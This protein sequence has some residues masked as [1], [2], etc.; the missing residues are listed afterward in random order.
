MQIHQAS[1]GYHRGH[2]L[3]AS[4]SPA[5]LDLFRDAAWL[6]DLPQT[7]PSGIRWKS[8]FRLIQYGQYLLL[9][10]TKPDPAPS[11]QGVVESR[12]AFIQLAVV[13]QINDL[14]PIAYAL[15]AERA[16]EE[17]LEPLDFDLSSR[18]P[19]AAPSSLELQIAEALISRQERP[20]I[21]V[22][23]EGFDEAM[24]ALWARVP[25]DFRPQLT[26]GLCFGPQGMQTVAVACTPSELA[27]EWKPVHL[28]ERHRD[29]AVPIPA[30]I[31]TLLDISVPSSVRKI[32]YDLQ[33]KLD[34]A[35]SIDIGLRIAQLVSEASTA[36]QLISLFR[37][38]SERASGDHAR[39]IE[40]ST[41]QKLVLAESKWQGSD[42]LMM[43]NLDLNNV[44]ASPLM[45]A[46][47]E[48]WAAQLPSSATQKETQQIF[49]AWGVQ[50]SATLWFTALDSGLRKALANRLVSD[51]LYPSLWN[52]L[53]GSPSSAG[54]LL[55]LL[56][57]IDSGDKRLATACPADVTQVSA[58]RLLAELATNNCWDAC[59]RLLAVS[60]PVR[61]VLR[62]VARLDPKGVR[63]TFLV[64]A[65]SS[66]SDLDLTIAATSGEH[67]EAIF[68]AAEA[69]VRTPS[70][71]SE[72]DWRSKTWFQLLESALARSS[73]LIK[74]LPKTTEGLAQTIAAG[75]KH[76]EVWRVVAKT[77]LAD[78]TEVSGRENAWTLIPKA[79]F[80]Q[81]SNATAKGWLTRFEQ[82]Q[83]A[84][85][86]LERDLRPAVQ[87]AATQRGNLLEVLRRAPQAVPLYLQEFGFPKE[88]DA[89]QFLNDLHHSGCVIVIDTSILIGRMIKERGWK[90]AAFR[91]MDIFRGREDLHPAMRECL[92]L[93]GVLNTLWIGWWLKIPVRLTTDEAWQALEE[94]ASNLFPAGPNDSEIW[95]RSGGHKGD[96]SGGE[97]SGRARWHASMKLLR[98]GGLPGV[99]RLLDTMIE[100]RPHSDTLRQLKVQSF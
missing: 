92:L 85:G 60:R 33:L 40:I 88:E 10:H 57:G 99:H 11:R 30:A 37:F 74:A 84:S 70:I 41:I 31:A 72:F 39:A 73:N 42:V 67:N 6:T 94:E 32:A 89:I 52:A 54:Q 96:L 51:S 81:I 14:R 28:I 12:A 46:A 79:Y 62:E 38:L 17:P 23:Q 83:V 48:R 86:E 2:A 35:R 15:E 5:L 75:V 76:V 36:S 78:L 1:Y 27:R 7:L 61:D 71:L 25:Q 97:A 16:I 8:F 13:D 95:S 18:T 58:D 69:C 3:R 93:V 22:G 34:S 43:R 45:Q 53:L 24:L 44:T 66:A 20:L 65:V 100:D 26:F 4:S 80:T 19:V 63:K 59:G 98:S 29:T 21:V 90:S 55:K 82:G 77:S 68:L 91:L 50:A 56:S 64:N 49:E 9:I 87:S 47:L